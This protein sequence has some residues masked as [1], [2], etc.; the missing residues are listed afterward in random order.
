M[1]KTMAG[2]LLMVRCC[3]SVKF[4]SRTGL[5]LSIGFV[6][7]PYLKLQKG[8]SE[9]PGAAFRREVLRQISKSS[10]QNQGHDKTA[11]NV[12]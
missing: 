12:C 8:K 9:T 10:R 1:P 5:N 3:D 6:C 11:S 7:D 4:K 2:D